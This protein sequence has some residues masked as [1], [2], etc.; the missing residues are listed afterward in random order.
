M[1]IAF[2]VLV[3]RYRKRQLSE[4]CNS[5]D[6]GLVPTPVR[7]HE[8]LVVKAWRHQRTD[9][10][11]NSPYVKASTRPSVLSDRRQAIEQVYFGGHHVLGA[12]SVPL[13]GDNRVSFLPPGCKQAARSM[14]LQ[15]SRHNIDAVG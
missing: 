5:P 13:E 8:R 2:C 14:K 12:H 11:Q 9:A 6:H 10:A 3:L 1:G 4:S 7:P 15:A